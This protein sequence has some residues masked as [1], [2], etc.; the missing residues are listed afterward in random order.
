VSHDEETAAEIRSASLVVVEGKDD[1]DFLIALTRHLAL[2]DIQIEAMGGI[3]KL[4]ATLGAFRN[5]HDWDTLKSLAVVRDANGNPE[6][7]L[8]SV[9]NTLVSLDLAAPDRHGDFARGRPAT[10]IFILPD[11]SSRG[12]LETL[13]CSTF[14]ETEVGRCVE[15]FLRCAEQAGCKPASSDKSRVQSFLAVTGGGRY[16]SV[17][18][19]ARARRW[20][21]DHPALDDLR[22]FLLRMASSS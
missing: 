4:P 19:A 3:S 2:G 17:G 13:L 15:S 20:D 21:L 22:G 9:R 5:A 18:V 6:G 1:R 16:A 12:T 10:G 11:G 8:Q 7:A 14:S